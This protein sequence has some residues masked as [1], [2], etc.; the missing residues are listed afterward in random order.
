M[1]HAEHRR[2]LLLDLP[3]LLTRAPA[4]R[5]PVERTGPGL[6]D[7]RGV[8]EHL[9]QRGLLAPGA[10]VRGDL[11]VIATERRNRNFK[12]VASV[13]PSYLVKQ[14]K[15][16]ETERSLTHEAT[17]LR[18]LAARRD[19][20]SEH[21]PRC[22]DFDSDGVILVQDLAPDAE[23]INDANLR[24]R[25]FVPREARAI[26]RVAA[27]VHRRPPPFEL[28]DGS[29][30]ATLLLHRPRLGLLTDMS[31]GD[32]RLLEAAQSDP[33]FNTALDELGRAWQPSSLVH[34]DLK[35]D[36][37]VRIPARAAG[38]RGVAGTAG[39]ANAPTTAAIAQVLLVDWELAGPGD[40]RWDVGTF[41]STFLSSWVMSIPMSGEGASP[42]LMR[43][44]MFPLQKLQPAVRAFW[45]GYR[46]T[47]GLAGAEADAFLEVAVRF[48]AGR[49]VQTAFEYLQM[50]SQL[51]ANAVAMVQLAANVM[52]QPDRAATSLLGLDARAS[53]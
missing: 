22:A 3:G 10:V 43:L 18:R 20:L 19:R 13:G 37:V 35:W 25:R 33:P 31:R 23:S 28:R 36:N 32:L 46:R 16:P 53:R 6:L 45:S 2:R 9:L 34:G 51:S 52:R 14:A 17:V 26:G 27:L 7:E 29:L 41:L 50:S 4:P 39:R 47:A 24:R 42:H 21:L 15:N 5:P 30:P 44:A 49:L 11:R 12:V 8:V 1:L 40:P 48:A 38:P